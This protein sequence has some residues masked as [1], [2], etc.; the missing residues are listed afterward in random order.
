METCTLVNDE[1]G[2]KT[3][4]FANPLS[5]TIDFFINNDGKSHMMMSHDNAEVFKEELINKG[6]KVE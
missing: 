4:F 2:E 5:V 3:L 1:T 6:F